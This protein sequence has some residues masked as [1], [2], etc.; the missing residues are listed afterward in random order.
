M[1]FTLQLL[2]T[3]K[4]TCHIKLWAPTTLMSKF[5][6]NI[7]FETINV[8]LTR[9]WALAIF[10]FGYL[11]SNGHGYEHAMMTTTLCSYLYNYYNC[12]RTLCIKCWDLVKFPCFALLCTYHWKRGIRRGESRPKDRVKTAGWLYE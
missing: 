10:F 1:C 5:T 3:W 8:H 4:H 11:S 12:S 9:V 2:E 6:I 7:T